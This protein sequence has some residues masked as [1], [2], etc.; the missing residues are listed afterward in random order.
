MSGGGAVGRV[1][2]ASA[3]T[4]KTFSLTNRYIGLLHEGA[5][6]G[7]ILATTFT[8]QAAGE[9]LERVLGRLAKACE[10]GEALEEL[11]AHVDPAL[12]AEA[13]RGMLS[14]VFGSLHRVSVLTLDA[15]FMRVA[16]GFATEL[17][18]PAGWGIV[19]EDADEATRGEAL[20]RMLGAMTVVDVLDSLAALGG[21]A[22]RRSVREVVLEDINA[23]YA[24]YLMTR[25]APEAW[26]VV[27]RAERPVLRCS[28][29]ELVERLESARPHL[30]MTKEGR[31]N[32]NWERAHN[33]AILLC[34]EGR[35]MDLLDG[36]ITEKL[37]AGE[38]SFARQ[39]FD[40]RL[41]AAYRPAV[42]H[43]IA[44]AMHGL[45]R[46]NTALRG[47]LSRFD[48]AYQSMKLAS[49]RLRFDD[50]PRLLLERSLL[51]D[52]Q[53]LYERLDA[54]IDHVLLD[55]FQ[56]TSLTQFRLLKPMLDELLSGEGA[57]ERPRSVF[58]VGDEKQSLYGWRDAAPELLPALPEAWEAMGEG[59]P[60]VASYRSS[61]AV[62]DAVNTV[63]G[64]IETNAALRSEGAEPHGAEMA[65]TRW[66]AMF[67]THRSA[68]EGR[69]G[70]VVLRTAPQAPVDATAEEKGELMLQYAASRVRAIHDRAPWASV[71]VLLRRR[72]HIAA[73]LHLLQRAG[74]EAS[75]RGGNPVTDAPS[76]AAAISALRMA[77]HPG[78]SAAFYH[79]S[80]SPLGEVLGLE[81]PLDPGGGR[82]LGRALR[83]RLMDEGLTRML[84]D[85][86][87]RCASSMDAR[88][89][90]RFEQLIDLASGWESRGGGTVGEFVRFV[91]GKR[92]E[93]PGRALVQVMTI[94]SSKGLEFDA[95]VLPELDRP[96]KPK[97]SGGVIVHREAALGEV[98]AVTLT[99]NKTMR[100]VD[101]KL[102]DL[103]RHWAGGHVL[104][105]M[106]GLYVA[107]TRAVHMLEMIVPPEPERTESSQQKKDKERESR[108]REGKIEPPFTPSGVLL[109]AMQDDPDT[110]EDPPPESVLWST[111]HGPDW[112]EAHRPDSPQA[113]TDPRPVVPLRLDR[114]APSSGATLR[115]AQVSPSSLKDERRVRLEDRLRLVPAEGRER[116]SLLHAF[117]ERV[118]W[119]DE[120]G[121][122][123][124]AAALQ[125]IGAQLGY[126]SADVERAVADFG[127]AISDT[128]T[129]E[130]LKA[131]AYRA[132]WGEGCDL[133]LWRERPFAVRRSAG[134]G[135]SLLRGYFDRVVVVRRGG[136]VIAADV[137]D[138]K[139]DRVDADD[140]KALTARVEQYRLQLDAYR[141]AAG[142]LLGLDAEDVSARLVFLEVGRVVEA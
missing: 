109:A 49:G 5:E 128:E 8:R 127:R 71:G 130:V 103:Y 118:G 125:E 131:G 89:V 75:E 113:S 74:L 129:A 37:A 111:S 21:G 52:G 100:A 6:P 92:V 38:E 102:G 23:A 65:R 99:S 57:G 105:E 69:S 33:K 3:G 68:R 32:K 138:F 25:G 36:G 84:C 2:R 132:Q 140:A 31:P 101:A 124:D 96:L 83:T 80:T 27:G 29:E 119:I 87:G 133:E 41:V 76:V 121:G 141:E 93:V 43:A 73:L 50:L 112:A 142:V 35:W 45:Y 58:C 91:E 123:P 126:D 85:W 40:D 60:L 18:L 13:C 42:E 22:P 139:T 46:Q 117:F 88:G 79:V 59:E 106:C 67:S 39:P 81:D 1:V 86:L 12:T 72:T 44:L 53:V 70:K 15:F 77:S 20:G 98:D 9:I 66:V 14:R 19:E 17:G 62:I 4:G 82:R 104:E 10:G 94:H 55:E 122:I 95:V 110:M 90:E 115:F 7:A 51:A 78:D 136:R 137:L 120:A 16:S 97:S 108:R 54:R 30:A 134:R 61:P 24:A 47:L 114:R 48:E 107:M 135:P 116:G 11:R 63:F 28:V 26:E 64:S 56:D 34:R